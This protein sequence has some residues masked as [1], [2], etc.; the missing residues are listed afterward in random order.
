MSLFWVPDHSD[1]EGNEI[2]DELTK[3]GSGSHI[4]GYGLELSLPLSDIIM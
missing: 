3:M 1:I 2:A 4:Y